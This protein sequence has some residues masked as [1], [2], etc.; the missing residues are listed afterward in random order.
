MPIKKYKPTT[1]GR[2]LMNVNTFEEL[3]ASR[4]HKSLMRRLQKHAGRNN[5]GIITCRHRGG[6][7]SR[8]YRSVD[9]RQL[10]NPHIAGIVHSVEYDPNR[11]SYIMLVK[12]QN[13]DI[14]YLLAPQGVTIGAH[15]MTAPKTKIRPGNRL[16]LRHI[17]LGFEIHNLELSLNSGG[18]AVRS[19]GSC[20]TII[21]FD[22]DYAQIQMPS[23][24]VRM[25]HRDCYASIGRLSNLDHN[26]IMIGK[27]G[28]NRWKGKRPEV[29][30]KAM[31]PCDHP[32]GGGEAKNQ[33][34]LKY[35][36]T[37]WG[38]HALGV[39]TRNRKKTSQRL[40]I[41]TRKGRILKSLND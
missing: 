7:V 3:T 13:G 16:Q 32:H 24:E 14:R 35:A 41:K 33:I 28:R 25:I 36:K 38:A 31:N 11:S 21:G 10:D 20:A 23:K 4:P 9:L 37:P 22:G 29:R 17:P 6:G 26:L 30:G 12:Y 18:Q 40:I 34:G 2:R 1:P 8:Q 15:V 39:L 5:R 19:A 27:A